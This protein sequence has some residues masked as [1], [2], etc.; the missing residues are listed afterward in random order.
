MVPTNKSSKKLLMPILLILC[1]LVLFFSQNIAGLFNKSE[2][3]VKIEHPPFILPAAYKVYENPDALDG[4]YSL[5]KMLITNTGKETAHN[6]EVLFDVPG[7]I[8]ETSVEKIPM[9]LPGQS[10]VVNC[11]PKFNPNIVEK[12][13]A[14]REKVN[15]KINGSNIED[16]EESFP[17][18]IKGRNEMIY[19]QIPSD[20]ITG[21]RDLF[22]NDALLSC[23]VTPEDPIVKYYTQQIQEKVLKGETAAVTNTEEEGLRFLL[24]IFQATL[25]SHM[26]YSG[27]GGFPVNQEDYQATGQNLRLPREV[28]TG[29]TGLCIELSLLYASIML[30]AGMEPVIYMIPGHAYPGFILNGKYYALE[31]TAIGGEGLK[32]IGTPESALKHGMTELEEFMKAAQSG[33][34]RYW[35]INIK[36]EISKGAVA[37]ELKDDTFLRQK[38][39]EIAKSFTSGTVNTQQ[40]PVVYDGSGNGNNGGG[41]NNTGGGNSGGGTPSGF[42]QYN[43]EVSFAY[44]GSW[45]SLSG[46]RSPYIKKVFGI[47]NGVNVQV[48]S[49]PGAGS[50]EQ[51]IMAIKQSIENNG[52]MVNYQTVGQENGF[53]VF[54]G[55]TSGDNFYISWSGA[56]KRSGNGYA[57]ITVN[58]SGS[59]ANQNDIG[60]IFNTL[61]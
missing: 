8:E 61:K 56:F 25:A 3:D 36:D 2:I 45:G 50:A 29:N 48:Y 5:F 23:F 4:K 47:Q 60:T 22:D 12:T 35:I 42:K 9:L 1:G 17:I 49:V 55:V 33:D 52:A 26:V 31:A 30:Q 21:Y 27:T 15:I 13:T 37:M 38:V 11:Y 46:Y 18:D 51:A 7:F 32:N 54:Q 19:T 57:G 53:T 24:G 58:T 34:P 28:I 10:F 40:L 6:I 43:G 16:R 20:E 14:S 44:P 39:D 41:G 59:G